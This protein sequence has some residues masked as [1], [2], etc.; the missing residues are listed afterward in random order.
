METTDIMENVRGLKALKAH[1]LLQR[2]RSEPFDHNQVGLVLSQ[3]YHPLHFFPTFLARH[4]ALS[5]NIPTRSFVS[6]I[7]WQELGEGQPELSHEQVYVTTMKSVGFE[8]A[9]FVDAEPLASTRALIN[10]YDG[11]RSDYLTSLGCLFAT[12]AAD[13]T[14]VAGIGQSVRKLTGARS[15]PWVDLHVRQE[16]DHTQSVANAIGVALTSEEITATSRAAE[17]MF[18]RWIDFFSGIEGAVDQAGT[19]RMQKAAN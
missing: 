14:M 8:T 2:L 3:W 1:S 12:E 10:E 18:S 13:L 4:V 5:P 6:K 11:A 19:R 15:L 16:P 9:E 17:N 7:L